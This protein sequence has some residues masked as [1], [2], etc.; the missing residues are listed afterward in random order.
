MTAA[1]TPAVAGKIGPDETAATEWTNAAIMEGLEQLQALSKI[2]TK[3]R[4][5]LRRLTQMIMFAKKAMDAYFVSRDTLVNT[6][7]EKDENDEIKVQ[8][9]ADGKGQVP[10]MKNGVEFNLAASRLLREA[11]TLSGDPPE[12]FKWDDFEHFQKFPDAS[13]LAGLGPFVVL[14]E[15]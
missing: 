4:G 9:T 11:A 8:L 7:G 6:W 1:G 10:V 5:M 3:N 15:K 13:I 12:P 2:G 14:S